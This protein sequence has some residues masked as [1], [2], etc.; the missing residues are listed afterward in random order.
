MQTGEG[1]QQQD[2]RRYVRAF[3]FEHR[4]DNA[5]LPKRCQA[6]P[7]RLMRISQ[8]SNGRK[9]RASDGVPIRTGTSGLTEAVSTTYPSLSQFTRPE[10][11]LHNIG[12]AIEHW[13]NWIG[14]SLSMARQSDGHSDI[15]SQAIET[16]QLACK[17]RA[18]YLHVCAVACTS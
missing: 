8:R 5:E 16:G 9:S 17:L 12:F 11:C 3:G 13:L 18:I 7:V 4:L 1:K 14:N 10:A 15:V 2:K 6:K